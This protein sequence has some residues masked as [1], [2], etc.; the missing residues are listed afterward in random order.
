M[1]VKNWHYGKL[2]LL[3]CWGVVLLAVLLRL[4]ES[5]N[6]ERFVLGTG[7]ILLLFG[8]PIVLSMLTWKWLSGKEGSAEGASGES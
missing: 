4:L 5:L 7:L 6:E 2:I 1:A 3:W 8:I